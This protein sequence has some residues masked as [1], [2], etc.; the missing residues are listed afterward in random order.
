M[1]KTPQQRGP[2]Q[3]TQSRRKLTRK[4]CIC[5]FVLVVACSRLA[6]HSHEGHPS[7][8]SDSNVTAAVETP[9]QGKASRTESTCKSETDLPGEKLLH[10][11]W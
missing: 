7:S 4:I 9:L 3:H 6:V 2:P 8:G 10:R 5:V 11:S 1:R